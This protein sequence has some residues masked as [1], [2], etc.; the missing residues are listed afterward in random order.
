MLHLTFISFTDAYRTSVFYNFEIVSFS[1]KYISVR[2]SQ[3]ANNLYS[4]IILSIPKIQA[5][6]FSMELSDWL[7]KGSY[8]TIWTSRIFPAK[9]TRSVNTFSKFKK[10][11]KNFSRKNSPEYGLSCILVRM[12]AITVKPS[13]VRMY[14]L[15][16]ETLHDIVVY[17]T[18]R[19][20]TLHDVVVY[21]AFRFETL[22]DVV[23]TS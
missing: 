14:T 20:E 13:Y 11:I 8:H 2:T 4:S 3:T 1:G 6:N 17:Y 12:M 19:F 7:P 10:N 23:K 22:H 9:A 15:R 18:F 21:Y 5:G 16:F